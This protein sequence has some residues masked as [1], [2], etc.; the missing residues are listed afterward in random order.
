MGSTFDGETTT[1]KHSL[2]AFLARMEQ[3]T[4]N[5]KTTT[6]MRV[7]CATVKGG[8]LT[9]I[10]YIM[11]EPD[12]NQFETNCPECVSGYRGQHRLQRRQSRRRH[13]RHV[14]PVG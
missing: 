7:K 14:H 3:L 6:Q 2:E 12:G 10:R 1:L 4:A 13:G 11:I 5:G 9:Y 8:V